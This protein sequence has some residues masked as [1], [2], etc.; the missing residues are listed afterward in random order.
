[1]RLPDSRRES[2]EASSLLDLPLGDSGL[3]ANR[4][5]GETCGSLPSFIVVGPP[6]TGTSWLH[7]ILSQY[8][9]L[10]NPTKET[11]FFDKHFQRGLKWYSAHY[12][13]FHADRP[14]GEIAPT[15]FASPQARERIAQTV[16]QA[17]LI[18]V[19]RNSVQRVVSL[20]RV[21][22]AYG[23]LPW[24]F[25]EAL[26]RDPELIASGKYATHLKEWQKVFPEEQIFPTFYDDLR[27]DPQSFV[28]AIGNFIG[29]PRIVLS[30]AQLGQ[31]FSSETMTEP[32]SFL[33]TRSATAFADLL[34]ARRLDR[35][36]AV[37]R[38]SSLIKLF[39][40]GG[41][42]FPQISEEVLH[43][44]C[45]VFRPEVD[46]LEVIVGRDLSA[47]K[48]VTWNLKIVRTDVL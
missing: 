35:V 8:T 24:S 45:Q 5:M 2:C 11:R 42:P 28:D 46:R 3:T 36:V 14:T 34:K 21:K 25:E 19:F 13:D 40:G 41:P 27:N 47:W 20:Y 17:K 6:R 26:D 7:E 16:P 30:K 31:V 39:L 15:Y 44:L 1:M 43:K 48:T 4:A 37:V 29:I 18:F 32:R 38:N 22:R 12:P 9:N 23:M 10:P 33:A